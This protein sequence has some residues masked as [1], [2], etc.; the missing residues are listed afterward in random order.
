[1]SKVKNFEYLGQTF[2]L[3]LLNQVIVDKE[4]SHS[5]LDVIEPSYFD[6][7]YF[8]T[9]I[10]LIKEYYKKYEC[11]PSF[12]TLEQQTKS[13]FPNET[14]LKILMDTIGQ[15][16]NSP[17]EGSQFV[18][19]KALKFCKQQELQKVMSK[20]QKVID[21]GEFENYDQLEELVRE[22]LQVGEREEGLSDV[23]GNLDEVLN[24]DFRHP[25]PMGIAGID[26]LLNGGLAK[27]EIG[28]I[29]AP[30]GVG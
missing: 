7:K 30:T 11:T 21:N 9:L 2:Q 13:E 24:D 8:K 28:V 4:F 23:F 6:N 5:I 20:A 14:M 22:A 17:F 19:E 18:Q 15:V 26:N 1:M 12:E 10:Q 3:Q 16:K 25:I 27:G 29:L